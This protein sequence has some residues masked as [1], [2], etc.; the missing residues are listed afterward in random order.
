MRGQPAL[1]ALGRTQAAVQRHHALAAEMG[2]ARFKAGLQLGRQVDLGHH[3]Q[4]LRGR[5]VGQH[6]G[7]GAQVHLGLA[8]AGGAKQQ[9]GPLFSCTFSIK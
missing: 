8:A 2:K 3:H 4:H 7:G 9:R 1:E 5:V 6:P